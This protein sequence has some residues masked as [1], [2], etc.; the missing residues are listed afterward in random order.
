MS[1]VGELPG[2]T[3]QLRMMLQRK[4]WSS[5]HDRETVYQVLKEISRLESEL[6]QARESVRKIEWDRDGC[7]SALEREGHRAEKAEAENAELKHD[8]EQHISIASDL[9][10]ENAELLGLLC[11]SRCPNEN[12]I[13]GAIPNQVGEQE[14]EAQQCQWCFERDLALTT[15]EKK[16]G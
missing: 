11:V 13:D 5:V 1:A 16:D 8:I 15:Q 6:K 2:A 10:T 7:M 9:A 14:W 12:C 3:N 4:V